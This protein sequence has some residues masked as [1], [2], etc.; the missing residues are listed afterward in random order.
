[1]TPFAPDSYEIIYFLNHEAQH[2][3]AFR[4]LPE[5][6]ISLANY[7]KFIGDTSNFL[8]T[9]E[10]LNVSPDPETEKA[11]A[12]KRPSPF[13]LIK[14]ICKQK[15]ALDTAWKAYF[16]K[17][18]DKKA[19]SAGRAFLDIRSPLDMHIAMRFHWYFSQITTF[20]QASPDD[21]ERKGFARIQPHNILFKPLVEK[22]IEK[23]RQTILNK[24]VRIERALETAAA[25]EGYAYRLGGEYVRQAREAIGNKD[26]PLQNVNTFPQMFAADRRVSV[27]VVSASVGVSGGGVGAHVMYTGGGADAPEVCGAGAGAGCG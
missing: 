12:P 20:C 16:E 2:N 21:S 27:E 4:I 3:D 22:K 8:K 5:G 19:K 26:H 23:L 18:C 14:T 10:S 25:G 9:L 1:M 11:Q 13:A 24:L 7:Q 17:P 6:S 15:K